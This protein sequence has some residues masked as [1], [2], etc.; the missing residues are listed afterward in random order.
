[1]ATVRTA[2]PRGL[3][4]R[5]GLSTI[6]GAARDGGAEALSRLLKVAHVYCGLLAVKEVSAALGRKFDESDIRQE[7]LLDVAQ[8]IHLFRGGSREFLCWLRQIVRTNAIDQQRR[9]KRAAESEVVHDLDLHDFAALSDADPLLLRE[10]RE[11]CEQAM[12]KLTGDQQAVLRLRVWEGLK[13]EE[14]GQRL[15][16]S[17]DA[18]RLLF[19][20]AVDA[21]R[22]DLADEPASAARGG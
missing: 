20:R 1:M 8:G 6:I 12:N 3:A 19:L 22:G 11:L 18:A 4:D 13:W 16:R 17:A 2:Y 5:S 14:I 9:H 10:Q 15:N 7:C 21:V